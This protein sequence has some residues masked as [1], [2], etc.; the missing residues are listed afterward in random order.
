VADVQVILNE[1]GFAVTMPN[2][3][4]DPPFGYQLI[5]T[6]DDPAARHY[7]YRFLRGPIYDPKTGQCR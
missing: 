3:M 2:T 7:H 1:R 4:P 6:G 5:G